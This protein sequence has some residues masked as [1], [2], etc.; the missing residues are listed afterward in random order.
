MGAALLI[1]AAFGWWFAMQQVAL[2]DAEAH[3]PPFRLMLGTAIRVAAVTFV[4]YIYCDAFITSRAELSSSHWLTL[5]GLLPLLSVFFGLRLPIALRIS[6]FAFFILCLAAFLKRRAQSQD[7]AS[8]RHW[9]ALGVI[10]L[11]NVIFN[12]YFSPLTVSLTPFHLPGTFNPQSSAMSS[13]FRSFIWIKQFSLSSLDYSYWLIG[14]FT[15]SSFFSPGI[16][17]L[18]LL[19]DSPSMDITAYYRIIHWLDFTLCIAGSF[20]F[21]LMLHV[22]MRLGWGMSAAA[23]MFYV[24]VEENFMNVLTMPD[25]C[26]ASSAQAVFPFALCAVFYALREN[27]IYPAILAGAA[28]AFSFVLLPPHFE[29]ALYMMFTF[30]ILAIAAAYSVSGPLLSKDQLLMMFSCGASFLLTSAF[31]IVPTLLMQWSGELYTQS[32][33]ELA[34]YSLFQRMDLD[35]YSPALPIIIAACIAASYLFVRLRG[36]RELVLPMSALTLVLLLW[37]NHSPLLVIVTGLLHM[38]P[39]YDLSAYGRR[40]YFITFCAMMLVVQALDKPSVY[41]SLTVKLSKKHERYH[42]DYSRNADVLILISAL[43]CG[44]LALK[45]QLQNY[46]QRCPYYSLLEGDLANYPLLKGDQANADRIRN[47]LTGFELALKDYPNTDNYTRQYQQALEQSRIHTAGDIPDAAGVYAFARSV[48]PLIDRFYTDPASNCVHPADSR[49]DFGDKIF[50][51]PSLASLFS[52]LPTPFLRIAGFTDDENIPRLISWDPSSILFGV[53]TGLFI[54]NSS[55]S[56]DSRFMVGAPLVHALYLLP[57]ND[58]ITSLGTWSHPNRTWAWSSTLL[59]N[60]LHRKLFDI[61]GIDV[62][63]TPRRHARQFAAAPGFKPMEQ[64]HPP[65]FPGF[66]DMMVLRN[67]QSYGM[68]YL[69]ND[70]HYIPESK[71]ISLEHTVKQY[72]T[73]NNENPAAFREARAWLYG[74]LDDLK[75]M[76]DIILESQE[77]PKEPTPSGDVS[78][79]NMLGE[80]AVMKADCKRDECELVYNLIKLPGWFAYA[81][82]KPIEISRANFAFMAVP[83]PRGTHEVW[84]VYAPTS[85]LCFTLLSLIGLIVL[86]FLPR[87]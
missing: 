75:S 59:F 79:R 21:Y 62:I 22:G 44:I 51:L 36:T 19:T 41:A 14:P 87:R 1:C 32:H 28:L 54:H 45:P 25:Y 46:P 37:P 67:H 82:G 3:Y 49:Y 5:L 27:R 30:F 7:R 48:A 35:I 50:L 83:L 64:D 40:G 84:F 17:L 12:G 16:Q 80:A 73:H 77:R 57:G 42:A 70:I 74:Q 23:G 9:L 56:F 29:M 11:I 10:F 81:D 60:P 86:P 72:L 26:S 20:G 38:G 78:I 47:R 66:K 58:F 24:F 15:P 69:A 52:G 34:G 85:F 33:S 18:S 2:L 76:Y 31:Y 13:A 61:A 63:M 71:V 4:V 43:L 65:T 55:G 8:D 53:G 6:L 39:N 68:A